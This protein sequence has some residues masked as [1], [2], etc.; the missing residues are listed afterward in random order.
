MLEGSD[1][2]WYATARLFRQDRP[3][4]W[5]SVFEAMHTELLRDYSL[6]AL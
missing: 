2:H 1:T 4:R 3:G 6:I 5:D